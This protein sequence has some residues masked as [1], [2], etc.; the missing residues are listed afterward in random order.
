MSVIVT[1]DCTIRYHNETYFISEIIVK[2][3]LLNQVWDSV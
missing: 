3:F 1:R 2:V